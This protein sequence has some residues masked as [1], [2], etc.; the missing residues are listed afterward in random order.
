MFL[1]EM[2][3]LVLV[4]KYIFEYLYFGVMYLFPLKFF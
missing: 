3:Y 1:P 2:G 4:L